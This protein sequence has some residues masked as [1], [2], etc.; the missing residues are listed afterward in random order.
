MDIGE[1]LMKGNTADYFQAVDKHDLNFLNLRQQVRQDRS[2]HF[3]LYVKSGGLFL[4]RA[5]LVLIILEWWLLA[6]CQVT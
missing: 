2:T 6:E 1:L 4:E 5:I 3:F